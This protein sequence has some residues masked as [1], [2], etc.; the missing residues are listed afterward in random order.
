MLTSAPPYGYPVPPMTAET[1]LDQ[2]LAGHRLDEEEALLLWREG[3]FNSLGQVAHALRMKRA[4]P[5]VATYLVDRNINYSNVCVTDCTFCGFYRS[6]GHAEAYVLPRE[7]LGK[8]IEETLAVGG[9]RILMQG[10]HHP[11]LRL[12][13]YCDLLRWIRAT[14]PAIEI[15]AFSPSEIDNIAQLEKMSYEEVLSRLHDA[16]LAGLPG[17]G[18]EILDDEVRR[19]VSPKKLM[20]DGWLEVMRVAHR[21]GL[22]TTASMV[23]GLGEG[24][25]HRVRHLLRVRDLQDES[26]ASHGNGF[27]AFIHWTLQFDLLPLA[28]SR[29]APDLGAT[30]HEYLRTLA[31][32][33]IVLDNFTHVA[34][35]WPTMGE[36]VAQVALA[37]G[38]DD[39]GSTML[40]ENVVS[41]GGRG[42]HC[43]M[44]AA[45]IQRHI[46]EAGFVPVQRDTRYRCVKRFEAAPPDPRASWKPSVPAYVLKAQMR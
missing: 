42:T 32:I 20:T 2:I 5:E 37:F 44:T 38:A 1:L 22:A 18:A 16:G 25:E 29:R 43:T 8:K 28:R 24:I 3:D 21:L 19:I 14:Y 9:T 31:M 4:D 13:W 11:D 7:V 35:S 40:E 41:Q 6:P 39:F 27:T 36:K 34:A 15:D 30:A 26:L 12:E 45:D 17:G 33:R 23:I 10:G 46:R